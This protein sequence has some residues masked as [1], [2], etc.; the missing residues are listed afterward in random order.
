MVVEGK[1]TRLKPGD[2]ILLFPNHFHH[3]AKDALRAVFKS[4][5]VK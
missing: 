5:A 3:Y 4:K 2:A 1:F